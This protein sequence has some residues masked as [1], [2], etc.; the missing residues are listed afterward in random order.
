M[1]GDDQR[2]VTAFLEMMAAER[3][4]AANTLEA[5]R[6]D[7]ADYLAFLGRMSPEKGVERAIEIARRSGRRL[8]IAAKIDR[9]E[10][11]YYRSRVAPLLS[12]PLVD[13]IGEV[14]EAEKPGFLGNAAAL[15]FP[16][17]W[18]EPFGLAMIEAM[19]CGTPVIAWPHGAVPEIVEHGVTGLVVG[20]IEEAVRAVNEV[21]RLDR[22]AVRRR[23][24][25]RFSASRMA[26]DYLAIYRSL[27]RKLPVAAE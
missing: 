1:S 12:D 20:S 22:A 2:H 17:D 21:P 23:F 25:E 10:E 24:E 11:D 6:R 27:A 4:A 16:I 26:R 3:G 7:L 15:L 5:Y 9:T 18:P 8:R 14:G 13:F 19:S